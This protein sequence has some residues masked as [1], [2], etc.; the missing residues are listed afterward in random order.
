MTKPIQTLLVIAVSAAI[1]GGTYWYVTSKETHAE[2]RAGTFEVR[3]D[4][5]VKIVQPSTKPLNETSELRTFSTR[6]DAVENKARQLEAEL[7]RTK[8]DLQVAKEK[9]VALEKVTGT[10]VEPVI[11]EPV[12]ETPVVEEPIVE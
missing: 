1:I 9:V 6:I 5:G 12:V 3:D 2:T 4:Q 8:V 11:E 7:G 10:F